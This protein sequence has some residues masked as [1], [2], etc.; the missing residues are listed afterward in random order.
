[1]GELPLPLQAQLLRV[2]QEGKYKRVGGNEWRQTSF[3]LVCATN[4]DLDREVRKGRF[5]AD[6][7][8]RIASWVCQVPALEERREDIV[9]LARHF[10]RHSCAGRPVPDLDPLVLR[11]LLAR[12]YPG[13]V[14]ELKQLVQRLAQRHLG[15][16]PVT[17]GCVP[18]DVRPQ[19]GS[20]PCVWPDPALAA[21]I[22]HALALGVGLKEISATAADLAISIALAEEGSNVQ[23]AAQRLGVTDRAIQMRLAAARGRQAQGQRWQQH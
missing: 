4:R 14:R 13:N 2:V 23:R 15:I 16:G 6:L 17:V 8:Y 18:E 1:V 21:C 12:S 5:R 10:L 3:R 7:Y 9:P 19:P 11:F 22:H 20:A